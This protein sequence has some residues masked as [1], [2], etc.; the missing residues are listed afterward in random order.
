MKLIS[1]GVQA[2]SRISEIG[3]SAHDVL[4]IYMLNEYVCAGQITEPWNNSYDCSNDNLHL[5][6][7]IPTL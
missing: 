1:F 5:C 3:V 2:D 6:K 7:V 4:D